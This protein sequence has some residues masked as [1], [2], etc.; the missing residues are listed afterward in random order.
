MAADAELDPA[1]GTT[2]IE[3]RLLGTPGL[4]VGGHPMSLSP[5]DA[6]LLALVALEPALRPERAAALLWPTAGARQADTS[7]RQRLYRLRRSCAAPLVNSGATLSLSDAVAVDRRRAAAEIERDERAVGGELLGDLGYDDLPEFAEWLRTAREEWRRERQQVLA[8]AAER[9]EKAGALVRALAYAQRHADGEPLAEHGHRRLMRLHYLRG[10]RAAA[11]AVFESL[12]RR[13]KDEL[14]MR[15]SA[16]TLELLATIERGA[17]ALPARRAVAPASLLRPPRLIGREREWRALAE[18]WAL[19]QVFVV[20]GEAG[21]GK[22]RLIGDFVGAEPGVVAIKVRSGDDRIPDA[23]LARLARAVL[24]AYD[25]AAPAHRADLAGLLP[26][27]GSAAP[28]TVG[29]LQRMGLQRALEALLADAQ[30]RGLRALVVDDVHGAD[31]ASLE[32]MRALLGSDALASLCWGFAQRGGEGRPGLAGLRAAL[33]DGQRSRAV[34]LAPL[35]EPEL[36]ELVA[37]LGVPE[38]DPGRLA[39]ALMRQGGGNPMFAIETLRDLVLHGAGGDGALPRPSTVTALVERRLMQLS[40][41]A[42]RLARLAALAGP[43]FDAELA[44]SV[45]ETHPLDMAEPWRE[46]ETAQVIRDG[47]F[48]HDLVFEATRASVPQPIAQLLHERIARHL[49][50]RGAEPARTA[51]HWAGAARWREA[52]LAYEAAARRA[53]A[54]SLRAHEVDDWQHAA[55]AFDHAGDRAAAFRARCESVLARIVVQGVAPARA[56]AESLAASAE[57]DAERAAAQIALAHAALMAADHA[58]GI[59]A[60]AQAHA[61]AATLAS[62]PLALEAA[63]LQAVGLTQ[64][65]RPAEALAIIEPHRAM[66]D[67]GEAAP[68]LRG[69]FWSDYAYALNGVRRLRDTASALA[70]AI[71]NAQDLG[72][73]SELA[74]LTSNLATV[75]GNLGAVDEA[76]A[77]AQRALALQAELGP[78]DGPEGGV[79]RTYVGLYCGMLGRYAEALEHVDA[80]LAC[81]ARDGQALWT[82]I[83]ANHKAQLMMELG[84]WARARQALEYEAPTVRSV[85]ARRATLLARVERG[86][87]EAGIGSGSLREAQDSLGAGDDPHVRMHVALEVA[88]HEPPAEAVER[89]DEVE[90]WALQLEFAGVALKAALRTAHARARAG[91]VELAAARMRQLVTQLRDMP[92]ADLGTA[93]AWW[94]A[95]EVFDAAGDRDDALLALACGAQWLRR[96]ALPHVPEPFR[97][98]FLQRNPSHRFLLAAAD[99]RSVQ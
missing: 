82:A 78:T 25:A 68:R 17:S 24:A 15:P 48:A 47:A 65:G 91:Q 8:M 85:R 90:R 5:K 71:A 52:G 30:S 79:V 86:L 9:C 76:L 40:P 35:T 66:V 32:M 31:E 27:L 97:D 22:S 63:C 64:A 20:V 69:R 10:D 37:S 92:P 88:L 46:L 74:T 13:L 42:L 16:E 56:L 4:R 81:F 23:V 57:N 38:L 54:Q 59:A 1:A 44:T 21:I 36:V 60:A 80:A 75:K 93:E 6:A 89:C 3:L 99:R 55:E 73:L 72:D 58:G 51:P 61:L 50:A 14:G 83:A 39:P 26:E 62:R 98:S 94:I 41:G 12:E 34:T 84:Q 2:A 96:T 18:A 11:I 28:A 7:L 77:L 70:Q 45:L 67:S 19:G 95:A 43:A 49:E 29:A 53:Q 87:G 33:D